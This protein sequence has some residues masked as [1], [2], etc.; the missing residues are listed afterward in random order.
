MAGRA[1]LPQHERPGL[2]RFFRYNP[3]HP[4]VVNDRR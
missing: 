2:G 3:D 4:R 1:Q